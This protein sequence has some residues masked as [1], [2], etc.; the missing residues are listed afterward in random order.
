MMEKYMEQKVKDKA[1]RLIENAA[2][3]LI[4]NAESIVGDYEYRSDIPLEIKV[5][6][7]PNLN[8]ANLEFKTEFFTE[9]IIGKDGL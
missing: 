9:R 6:I 3:S 7:N 4:K 2:I 5:I 8:I 1:I